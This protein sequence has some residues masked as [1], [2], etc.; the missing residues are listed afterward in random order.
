MKAPQRLALSSSFIIAAAARTYRASFATVSKPN[1]MPSTATSTS[2][3][4][5]SV[6]ITP[7]EFTLTCSDGIA[8]A[9]QIWKPLPYP[10]VTNA[11]AEPT[12]QMTRR[13]RKLLCVHGWMDNCRS[14]HYFAPNILQRMQMNPAI[15]ANTTLHDDIEIVAIDLPGHGWS[16][17]KSLDGPPIHITDYVYYI[18]EA[19]QQLQWSTTATTNGSTNSMNGDSSVHPSED[20]ASTGTSNDP[21]IILVGHSM[22]AAICSMYA[23]TFPERVHKLVLLEGGT[24][25]LLY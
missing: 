5:N 11:I 22:G 7:T 17:H 13:T 24:Y 25:I 10:V 21:E 14:Y 15:H 12:T 4:G 1:N 20:H 8:L 6:D 18:A 3:N 23:A 19:I 2:N 9:A 16:S